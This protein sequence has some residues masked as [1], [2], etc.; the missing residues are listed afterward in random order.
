MRLSYQ[1][2]PLDSSLGSWRLLVLTAGIFLAFIASFFALQSTI[3]AQ[4]SGVAL[5]AEGNQLVD[6]S[7]DVIVLR[8]AN[9]IRYNWKWPSRTAMGQDFNVADTFTRPVS[10]GGWGANSFTLWVESNPVLANDSEYLEW[11]DGMVDVAVENGAYVLFSWHC[12]VPHCSHP[13][14]ISDRG[15]DAMGQV[16]RRFKDVPNVIYA[17]Q[18]EPGFY[19]GSAS[20][21]RELRDQQERMID[22]I[23]AENPDALVGVSGTEW[24]QEVAW[25]LDDPVRRDNIFV[26]PHIYASVPEVLDD[27]QIRTVAEQWP[28]VIGEFG[29]GGRM[30]NGDT[31]ELIRYAD[32]NL[33]GW[34]AWNMADEGPPVML[35]SHDSVTPTTFGQVVKRELERQVNPT[36][37]PG[38]PPSEPEP[39]PEPEPVAL[40]LRINAGGSTLE[41]SDGNTW[42]ADQE[43]NASTS[44]GYAGSSGGA[45]VHQLDVAGTDADDIFSSERWGLE[46]YRIVVPDGEY[47]VR[48]SFAET[49]SGIDGSG[50]RVFDVSVEGDVAVTALDA[51]HQAGFAVALVKEVRGVVVEDGRLDI[52]FTP[53]VEQPMIKG[54]EVWEAGTLPDSPSPD[55]TPEPEPE[56]EPDFES[57]RI[58]VGGGEIVANGG[59]VW[60]ADR[61]YGNGN[62]WGYGESYDLTGTASHA[63]DVAGTE[64]DGIFTTERWGVRSYHVD[65]PAD[66]YDIRLLFAETFD[67]IAGPGQ[68]VF[69]IN[70]EETPV[71]SGLDIHAE[72]GFGAALVKDMRG[73][74][75]DDGRLDIEFQMG[76]EY[77]ILKGIEVLPAGSLGAEPEPEP[78]PEPVVYSAGLQSW[79]D[80][81][82]SASWEAFVRA[83]V[84]DETFQ[85]VIGAVVTVEWTA[86]GAT[87]ASTCTTGLGGRCAVGSGSLPSA[88]G[89]ATAQVMD[90]EFGGVPFDAGQGEVNATINR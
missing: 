29:T 55:P 51:Y 34:Q 79:S 38:T 81:D 27:R 2:T 66:E 86:E 8:G 80:A 5:R 45:A 26:K 74:Q 22:S 57:L 60:L 6:E 32:E 56:P 89:T 42:Q 18:A 63:V 82:G 59:Q 75:V 54:I 49:W 35:Q 44:W 67:G 17:T 90:I 24:S 4:S 76:V 40:P 12:D 16:A 50:Q 88:T 47:D 85:P 19:T 72:A 3:N 21:W 14:N 37:N 78:E 87:H 11:M 23:R 70:V 73:V 52:A 10:Q 77:P 39:E 33:A 43:W 46:A 83:T 1:K 20:R 65:L 31:Q 25:M 48:L 69:G 68:R 58:N 41:D 53:G 64:D 36:P 7:G 62:S 15:I 84:H 28:V 71:V 13:D 61:A 9:I 30:D